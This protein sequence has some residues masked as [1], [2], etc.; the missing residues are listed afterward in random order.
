MENRVEIPKRSTLKKITRPQ[1][2]SGIGKLPPQ[3]IDLEEAILGALMLEKSPLNDVIDIIH[4]PEIFYKEAHQKIYAAIQDL[5]SSSESIDILTVTQKLKSNGDLD[6][7]GGAYYISQ[8]TNRIASA[9]HAESH[10]RIVVQKYILREMIRISGKVIQN[11]YDETTDVF[12][13]LDEAESELFKVTEGNIRKDYESMASLLFK[14]QSEIEIAMQK[15]DGIN[16][17]G[18]GFKELD[19]IT[20]GWQ[21]SDMIVVA[22]RPGLGKTAFVLSMARNVAVDY[23]HP[24]AIFSLE[25]SSIQLVNRLISGEAEIPA[26]DI[27]RGNFS[28]SEFEQFFERTK[29][30]S[31]API[32]ID[33]TPALSIFELRAKSRRLKQ[34]HGVQLII[35]DYLQ[36]MSSGGKG[37][38]REQE[39]SNIS[40]SIKEIAKELEIPIIALSQLSRSVETRGGDKRP[41]L[42]DL[43]DSGAIEQDADIVGFIYRPEYYQLTE[44]PDGSPCNN[45]GEII[46]AKHRNG[47]LKDVRLKFIGKYAKFSDLDGLSQ[48]DF[49]YNAGMKPNN[50]FGDDVSSF[51]MPSKMN[52]D[53]SNEDPF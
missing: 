39:I 30:L 27:R 14:A 1:D 22:A 36:L 3:A 10:A 40:R 49:M 44:W 43:R 9:A 38:N 21:K 18:S 25:M 4:Q 33:D 6:S 7:V 42:S 28:K 37:G 50:D 31:E 13:L 17:I 5:F 48:N 2:L 23:K 16:G 12:N 8:L 46:I 47:S 51:T 15:E 35:I 24:V 32:Y 53:S 52:D 29:S 41:M 26:E 19:K 11:A 34:Q 20:S 45:Q